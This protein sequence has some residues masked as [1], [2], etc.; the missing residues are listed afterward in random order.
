MATERKGPVDPG[1]TIPLFY[2]EPQ[3]APEKEAAPK[4][5][6]SGKCPRCTRDRNVGLTR[7]GT[8]LWWRAHTV[9]THGKV[10]RECAASNGPLHQHAALK[11]QGE[12]DP[13]TC[14]CLDIKHIV[15]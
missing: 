1:D 13:K 12:G 7:A 2:V 15:R 11:V 3:P 6:A 10:T 8:C 4:T 9:T 5:V 14:P